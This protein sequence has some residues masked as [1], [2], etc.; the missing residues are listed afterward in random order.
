LTVTKNVIAPH[1]AVKQSAVN[2]SAA[3]WMK[4]IGMD[5]VWERGI[6]GDKRIATAVLDSDVNHLHPELSENIWKSPANL[7]LDIFGNKVFCEAGD[8]GFD[9]ERF[10]CRPMSSS[11]GDGRG[12]RHGT[13]IAGVIGGRLSGINR[14]A[15]IIPVRVLPESS[16]AGLSGSV[17]H[18]IR[19][20]EF[21]I[22]LKEVC[23][24][25]ADVRVINCSLGFDQNVVAGENGGKKLSA[26]KDAAERANAAGILI[27]AA[28]G[29]CCGEDIRKRPFYPASLD[30]ENII[31]VSALYDNDEVS[32]TS[33]V[34][35]D[36]GAPGIGIYTTVGAEGYGYLHQTSIAAAFVSGAAALIL[37]RRPE[38]S[39][40][41]TREL[42]LRNAD[43]LGGRKE[44]P[45]GRLNVYK[46]LIE[47]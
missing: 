33:S 19:G 21:A 16:P 27:V 42:I 8:W 3:W 11:G 39:P 5:R 7:E 25:A 36:I 1:K 32:A 43:A 31:S 46:A 20:I 30:A 28:A 41:E 9:A 38:L 14:R 12:R 24:A 26:L 22:R 37:S 23:K 29:N 4:K 34:G 6:F 15:S 13:G 17:E 45:F 47:C 10:H 2:F 35:A 44:P 18:L 40:K